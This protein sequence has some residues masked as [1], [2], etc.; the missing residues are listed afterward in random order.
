MK[1]IP[2]VLLCCFDDCVF[3]YRMVFSC[4]NG[5]FNTESRYVL[6]LMIYLISLVFLVNDLVKWAQQCTSRKDIK[7][8][9]DTLLAAS[10]VSFIVLA[11][12]LLEFFKVDDANVLK[13]A[14]FVCGNNF[15]RFFEDYE[16]LGCLF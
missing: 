5:S 4:S 15:R 2:V 8:F 16:V 11:I 1:L 3:V 12:Y 6:Y 7:E 13:A 10:R 14:G 9:K